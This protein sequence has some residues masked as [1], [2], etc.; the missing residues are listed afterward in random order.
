ALASP[1]RRAKG[2][3]KLLTDE[4]AP[5]GALLPK[6]GERLAKK[7]NARLDGLAAEH[8][9]TVTE[10]VTKIETAN[11]RR[12]SMTIG[13]EIVS[14]GV[15]TEATALRD[16]DRDTRRVV[17]TIKEGVAKD[18]VRYRVEKDGEDTDVLAVRTEVAA[19]IMVDGVSVEIDAAATQWVQ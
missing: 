9:G 8:A 10:N 5:G 14:N 1:L 4:D 3:A 19:L 18:Y 6:A 16:I 17:A 7:L 13:G 2:L 11:I 15:R 12:T